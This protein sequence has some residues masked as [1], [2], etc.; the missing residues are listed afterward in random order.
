MP[1]LSYMWSLLGLLGGQLLHLAGGGAVHQEQAGPEVRPRV[2]DRGG[3][4]LR[5]RDRRP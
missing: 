1:I 5:G 3:Q 2:D 4:E